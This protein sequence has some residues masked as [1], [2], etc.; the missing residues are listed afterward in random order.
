MGSFVQHGRC[1]K[2]SKD[3][4]LRH[5]V[6]QRSGNCISQRLM[7]TPDVYEAVFNEDMAQRVA[8]DAEPIRV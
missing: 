6:V 8:R 3:V 1:G 5:T 2:M 4:D 7:S